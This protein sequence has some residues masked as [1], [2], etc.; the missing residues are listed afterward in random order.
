[1]MLLFYVKLKEKHVRYED[2]ANSYFIFF[3]YF[4]KYFFKFQKV[5][6]DEREACKIRGR[7]YI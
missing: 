2:A 6:E 1:M 5:W 4:Y 3:T 7:R